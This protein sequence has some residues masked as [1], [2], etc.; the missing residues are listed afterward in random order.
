VHWGE[1]QVIETEQTK[2]C[3][4][5]IVLPVKVGKKG[6]ENDSDDPVGVYLMK[7]LMCPSWAW[8]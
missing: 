1:H 4:L 5:I 7:D 3:F 8:T 6:S 2:I